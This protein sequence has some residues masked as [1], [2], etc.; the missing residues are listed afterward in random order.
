M[1]FNMLTPIVALLLALGSLS[2]CGDDGAAATCT[3]GQQIP[4]ACGGGVEGFQR[5]RDDGSGYDA[6]VCDE[7]TDS[8][9]S[10]SSTTDS[11]VTDS[12]TTDSNVADSGAGDTG[13]PDAG[14]VCEGDTVHDRD[15]AECSM[16]VICQLTEFG[17]MT[18]CPTEK[19]A[20]IE[21]SSCI[22]YANCELACD[23]DAFCV[24]ACTVAPANCD[25]FCGGDSACLAACGASTP[26][27][28]ALYDTWQECVACTGCPNSCNAAV[29]CI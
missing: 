12:G 27:A 17:D 3:A 23:G 4:C 13:T 28:A 25:T 21:D 11:S 22:D 16:C 26:A 7:P 14:V 5:C 18:L 19:A 20:C 15:S 6:C 2:G 29:S 24:E 9:P 10:D 8:G 1:I